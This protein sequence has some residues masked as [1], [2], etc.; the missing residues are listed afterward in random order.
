MKRF[1][2]SV[3]TVVGLTALLSFMLTA[4]A[5]VKTDF[6]AEA[7]QASMAEVALS[8]L[9]L[10]KS[11]N[12]AVRQFAQQMV[13]DHTAASQELATLASSKNVTL[14]AEMDSKHSGILRKLGGRSGNDFDRDYMKAMVSDHEKAVKLFQKEADKGTDAETKAWA[15]KMVPALQGHLQMARSTHAMVQGGERSGGNGS[16]NSGGNMN[17]NM[18]MNS[19]SNRAGNSSGRSNSNRR[20]NTNTS[21]NANS[22][23]NRP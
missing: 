6:M 22:N 13:T 4:E 12:E 19:I 16:G 17:S 14:P 3:F 2:V 11:Q 8:N 9:A 1:V 23:A 10:Q 20:T 18:D 21:E 7:A 5:V 15:A